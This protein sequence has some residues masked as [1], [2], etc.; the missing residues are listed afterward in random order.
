MCAETPLTAW[1]PCSDAVLLLNAG[2]FGQGRITSHRHASLCPPAP[3]A[4]ADA[5][6]LLLLLAAP[7]CRSSSQQR[8]SRKHCMGVATESS[9][10][11][12]AAVWAI[13]MQHGGLSQ[14]CVL[15]VLPCV[16]QNRAV[17]V[18]ERRCAAR[19]VQWVTASPAGGAGHGVACC[20]I[21]RACTLVTAPPACLCTAAWLGRTASKCSVQAAVG[22][23]S[24]S[25]RLC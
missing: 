2:Q 5:A 22:Y 11:A 25:R 15:A 19:L 3:D 7:C 4:D 10:V 20:R 13:L 17:S 18:Q 6:L 1:P 9:A 23:G 8:K 21:R 12:L 24:C 16:Q 14:R